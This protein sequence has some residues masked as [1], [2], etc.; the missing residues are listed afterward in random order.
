M[1]VLNALQVS[2]QLEA[3]LHALHAPQDVPHVR[4]LP[5]PP[6][7]NVLIVIFI[8]KMSVL[9]VLLIIFH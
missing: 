1:P 3:L 5:Q 9:F 2:F 4:A 8:T 7:L 6:A